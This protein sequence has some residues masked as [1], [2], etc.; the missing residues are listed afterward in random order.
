MGCG[1]SVCGAPGSCSLGAACDLLGCGSASIDHDACRRAECV[2]DLDC[3]AGERCTAVY[4]L[5]RGDC[6]ITEEGCTCMEGLSVS[7]LNVCSPSTLVGPSGEWSSL[8]LTETQFT[9]VTER[10]FRPDG[11]VEINQS[12]SFDDSSSMTTAMLDETDLT[13]LIFIVNGADLRPVL[14]DTVLCGTTEDYELLISLELD[15]GT[16]E[17]DLAGCLYPPN[18]PAI[19]EQLRDLARR[20]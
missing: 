16:L 13:D 20:Y 14:S 10:T 1:T 3:A 2:S 11:T 6:A 5:S 12:D 8:T 7:P 17:R 18:S 9:L 4:W 15:T 19:V